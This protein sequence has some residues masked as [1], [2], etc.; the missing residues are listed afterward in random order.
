MLKE[1]TLKTKT[2]ILK[3]YILS[4]LMHF[5]LSVLLR[6]FTSVASV[7]WKYLGFCFVWLSFVF[8]AC[9]CIGNSVIT[10]FVEYGPR[11]LISR[12]HIYFGD[13]GLQLARF[14]ISGFPS[15]LHV[16]PRL[17][18]NTETRQ[19]W[20]WVPARTL[21]VLLN[22]SHLEWCKFSN[23]THGLGCNT[24]LIGKMRN[25]YGPQ[26]FEG[27][28][29]TGLWILLSSQRGDWAGALVDLPCNS[30]F[31]WLDPTLSF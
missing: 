18:W 28:E 21:P 7:W 1:M 5:T 6:L 16:E 8:L 25:Y 22:E 29:G 2:I 24:G 10:W 9:A 17:T 31:Q 23:I 15:E 26:V 4:I 12:S 3:I 20:R 14:L 13:Q 27:R 19:F 30:S 11:K